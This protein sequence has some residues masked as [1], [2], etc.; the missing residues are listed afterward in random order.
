MS[1]QSFPRSARLLT[2]ADFNV[3][4]QG[5]D[6][7]SARPQFLL[8]AKQRLTPLVDPSLDAEAGARIGFIV[9]KKKVRLAVERNRIK[10]QV[11]EVFRKHRHRL[12]SL[13]IVFMARQHLGDLDNQGLRREVTRA[14]DRLQPR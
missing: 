8:I 14:L 2:A 4:M 7:K 1:Q 3:V 10:R 6:C 13:D 5:S 11:R 9:P 12:P